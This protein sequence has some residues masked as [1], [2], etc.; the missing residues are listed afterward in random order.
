MTQFSGSGGQSSGSYIAQFVNDIQK[1]ATNFDTLVADSTQS[2]LDIPSTYPFNSERL[3]LITEGT[4]TEADNF[5]NGDGSY[6]LSIN[7][8]EGDA[9]ELRSRQRVTYIPNYEILWGIAYFMQNALEPGQRLTAAFTDPDRENGYFLRI[10]ADER[11]AFIKNGGTIVDQTTWGEA[12]RSIDPYKRDHLDETVPQVARTYL[13]WYGDGNADFTL[14]SSGPDADLNNETVAKVANRQNVA[15]GEINLK[16]SVR[17]EAT[18]D[19]SANTLEALSMGALVQGGG[20]VTNR[21]KSSIDTDLSIPS[22][23]MEPLVAF[24]RREGYKN[25]VTQLT[26]FTAI[27]SAKTR[28]L[29][30]A[31]PEGTTDATDWDVPPE[32]DAENSAVERTTDIS[33]FPEDA[34]GNP[35]GRLVG[36]LLALDGQGNRRVPTGGDVFEPFYEDE[37]LVILGETVASTTAQTDL[38]VR[39]RQEW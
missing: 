3:E 18:G 23:D 10:D 6:R 17:L 34:D 14:T 26:E 27:P 20:S 9:I 38:V 30:V 16:L 4:V 33:T 12:K 1:S 32:Q 25:I 19:T 24:R 35:D 7:G 39:T 21:L 31:F 37:E 8:T 5:E 22:D 36:L 13:S 11:T 28:I 2:I 29:A 15:T